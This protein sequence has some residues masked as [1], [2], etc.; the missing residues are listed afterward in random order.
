MILVHS[1]QLGVASQDSLIN[2]L[3]LMR[4]TLLDTGLLQGVKYFGTYIYGFD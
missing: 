2:Y 4:N 3:N 1:L